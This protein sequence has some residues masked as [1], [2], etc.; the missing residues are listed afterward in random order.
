MSWRGVPPEMTTLTI[1]AAE[2]ARA[3]KSVE[4]SA[5]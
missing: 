5:A 4:K 1:T 3:I 2:L